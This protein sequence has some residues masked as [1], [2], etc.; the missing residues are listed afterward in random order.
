[1]STHLYQMNEGTL[2]LPAG[3]RD[4]SMHVF[5]LP[6]DSGVNLVI[7]RTPV[8]AGADRQAYYEQTLAQFVTHL[9]GYQ[10]HQRQQIDLSGDTAWRLDYQWQSPEGEMH[11]TVVLQIRGSQLLAFN[12]TSPQPFEEGQRTALLAVITSFQAA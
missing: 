10:E 6:D 1:M 3:W 7:N 12:L 8:P 9:P 11:Q 4:E 5:V 2:T